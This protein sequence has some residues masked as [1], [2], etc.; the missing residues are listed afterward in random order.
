MARLE[1]DAA[2]VVHSPI[3]GEIVRL[4]EIAYDLDELF[5]HRIDRN[6]K[7]DQSAGDGA[8]WHSSKSRTRPIARL[9]HGDA[10][11]L[12]DRLDAENAVAAAPRQDDPDGGFAAVASERAE[13]YVDRRSL[14]MGWVGRYQPKPPGGD[15]QDRRRRNNIY[16]ILL[17]ALTVASDLDAHFGMVPQNIREQALPIRSQMHDDDEAHAWIGGHGAEQTLQR[18]DAARGSADAYDWKRYV[19]VHRQRLSPRLYMRF[20]AFDVTLISNV[21]MPSS[22]FH[23]RIYHISRGGAADGVPSSAAAAA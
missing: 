7:I 22:L 1:N 2:V 15:R 13:E 14:V 16:L 11:V 3:R 8:A 17:E 21:A 18:L 4:V 6:R 19:R 20:E 5:R 10:A 23:G 12:L 9:R